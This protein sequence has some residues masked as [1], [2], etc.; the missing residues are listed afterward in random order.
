MQF[1]RKRLFP[2]LIISLALL[3]PIAVYVRY[4]W[5]NVRIPSGWIRYTNTQGYRYSF[6]HPKEWKVVECGDMGVILVKKRVNKCYFPLEASREYLDNLYFQLFLP[7]HHNL[8]NTATDYK[9][10]V[11]PDK[12]TNWSTAGW[13]RKDWELLGYGWIGSPN[14]IIPVAPIVGLGSEARLTIGYI[15]AS[16]HSSEFGKILNSFRHEN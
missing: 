5:T 6:A 9:N 12:L 7:G 3:I 2:I 8:V 15:Y 13:Y 14:P 10:F 1:Y 4:W 11:W 16:H